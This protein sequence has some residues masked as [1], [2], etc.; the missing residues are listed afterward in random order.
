MNAALELVAPGGMILLFGDY[1]AARADFLWNHLL[2][3]E[4]ERIGSNASAGAWPE[5][6]RLAVE[7]DL[8]LDR[9]ITH[10][11]PAKQ[12][13]ECIELMRSHRHEGNEVV[14]EWQ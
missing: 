13:R 12:F 4:M 1:G 11:I 9:L 10:R 14:L 5:A 2:H 6:L 7:G 8:P 3:R